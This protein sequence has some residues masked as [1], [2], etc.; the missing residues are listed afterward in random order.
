[1]WSTGDYGQ[2]W[3]VEFWSVNMSSVCIDVMNGVYVGWEDNPTGQEQ[4]I[5]FYDPGSGHLGFINEGLTS[6]V[7]NEILINPWMSAIALFC[8]TDSGAFINV[9]YVTINEAHFANEDHRLTVC[10]NPVRDV[11]SDSYNLSGLDGEIK[12]ALYQSN[13][14]RLSERPLNTLSGKIEIDVSGL[15]PGYYYVTVG[16]Y[17]VRSCC[18][19]LKY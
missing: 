11:A 4:G 19:I 13:G 5:A 17:Q 10:P 7:I 12:L 1:L 3:E 8:C 18:K 9:D 16:D 2:S 14:K 6:L 15:S